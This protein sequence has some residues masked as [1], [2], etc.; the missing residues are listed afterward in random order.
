MLSASIGLRYTQ[1]DSIELKFAVTDENGETANITGD[2]IEFVIADESGPVITTADGSA[3]ATITNPS[4][5]LFTVTVAA[6]YTEQLLGTYRYQARLTDLSGN[7]A[8]VARG[9]IT[10]VRSLIVG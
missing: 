6:E 7:V 5:G 4:G 8:T 3:E 9:F 2:S 1:G 10:F